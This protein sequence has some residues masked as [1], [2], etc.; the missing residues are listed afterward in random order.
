M[1][2]GMNEFDE[3][4]MNMQGIRGLKNYAINQ[5]AIYATKKFRKH[6]GIDMNITDAFTVQTVTKWIKKY[7]KDFKNHLANPYD[8]SNGN[9]TSEIIND[10]FFVK[11]RKDTFMYVS[12]KL[13]D[14]RFNDGS[15][16]RLFLYIFGKKC[17]A[18]FNELSVF[19]KDHQMSNN[20]VY[21]VSGGNDG[22][23]RSY[24]SATA[25]QLEKRPMDTIFLDSNIKDE[26]IEHLNTWINNIDIYK[27]RGLPYKTGIL[28]YGTPGT[29]KSSMA[30]AIASYLECSLITIDMSSFSDINIA[31]LSESINAD[32]DRYVVLIDEI[33]TIFSSR[34]NENASDQEKQ[35]ISKLLAL[36][37][38]AQSPTNV[39][40]VATTNYYDKLDPAVVRKGRFD[41]IYELNPISKKTAYEMCESF[42]CTDL[43]CKDILAKYDNDIYINPSELQND[44][45]NYITKG[46]E[47]NG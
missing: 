24:W 13:I 11:L 32:N 35:N 38:S 21:T 1:N 45:L 23:G 19:I 33:D 6:F 20:A 26:V 3:L 36:L 16:P 10:K 17:Y 40:F 15:N 4:L 7:D 46:N 31:E 9:S 12:G 25:Q 30:I 39:V 34:D 28:F 37:D 42:G 43:Q 47:I 5:C 8:N 41:K 27:K 22:A 29:G 18:Y 44:I 2:N 14:S